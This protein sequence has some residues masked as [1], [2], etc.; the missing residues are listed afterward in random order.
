MVTA[1]VRAFTTI[2][3][4]DIRLDKKITDSDWV[5][6]LSSQ[7]LQRDLKAANILFYEPAGR[8]CRYVDKGHE[9]VSREGGRLAEQAEGLQPVWIDGFGRSLLGMEQAP[10]IRRYHFFS[11][12]TRLEWAGMERRFPGVSAGVLFEKKRNDHDRRWWTQTGDPCKGWN[13]VV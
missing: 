11:L 1:G 8:Y 5:F 7:L 3:S 9:C 13:E 2:H 6:W 4:T 10:M 12:S